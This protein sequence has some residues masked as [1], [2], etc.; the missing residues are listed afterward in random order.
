MK[1]EVI[2]SD[3]AL[4]DLRDIHRYI[5]T[6]LL[7]PEAAKNLSDKIM[8]EIEALNEMPNRNPLYDKEPWHSKG[9][10]KL[11]VDNFMA[12]YLPVEKQE[13]VLIVTIMYG[14]RNISEILSNSLSDKA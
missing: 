7:A 8:T 14:K 13:Q 10:R 5:A 11:V 4:N 12:F 1:F 9:L 2:Y 3:R 6:E